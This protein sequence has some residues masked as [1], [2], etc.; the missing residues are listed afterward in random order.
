MQKTIFMF[1][2]CLWMVGCAGTATKPLLL[3]ADEQAQYAN[4]SPTQLLSTAEGQLQKANEAELATYAPAALTRI[5]T[6]VRDLREYSK[7]PDADKNRIIAICKSV[8]QDLQAGL[9]NKQV[10]QT[11]LADVF[12]QKKVLDTLQAS[13]TEPGDYQD[14]VEDVIGLVKYIESGKA[15]KARDKTPG[16]M[17]AM[18]KLEIRVVKE[19]NL[20][21][22]KQ[23]LAKAEDQD[24]DDL[25][26][27]SYE[28]A[29]KAYE[30]ANQFI[31]SK[32][33]DSQEIAHLSAEALFYAKRSVWV[34][35]AV[36]KLQKVK[37]DE[38]ETVALDIE[39][40]LHRIGTA[41][42]QDVRDLSPYEQSVALASAAE[43]LAAGAH[44]VEPVAAPK[45]DPAQ[46]PP[47]LDMK[48]A[49][50]PSIAVSTPTATPQVVVP[51][52]KAPSS[53][54]ETD[55]EAEPGSAASTEAAE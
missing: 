10:A 33:R 52:T 39:Q 8:E 19:N 55:A 44:A 28:E 20:S 36:A 27:K 6:Q 4:I 49:E 23:V 9:A 51:T 14:V 34:A 25:A 15:D 21:K 1:F 48:M 35:E 13:K 50:P 12:E 47:V 3:S 40:L 30:R 29:V 7:K 42:R 38:L 2:G 45:N 41:L 46:Q 54:P 31:E 53:M 16:V 37:P 24:A 43:K 5:E 32:P 18:K 17:G 11:Q 22:V 26:E